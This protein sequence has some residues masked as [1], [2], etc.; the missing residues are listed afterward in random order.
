MY[1]VMFCTSTSV[2]RLYSLAKF[3]FVMESESCFKLNAAT[4]KLRS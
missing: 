2:E 1:F 3:Y 4:R